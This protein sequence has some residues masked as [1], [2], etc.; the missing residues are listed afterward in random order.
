VWLA[1]ACSLPAPQP[2]P[3]GAPTERGLY[4]VRTERTSPGLVL[5]L[6]DAAGH[7]VDDAALWPV[8][9]GVLVEPGECDSIEEARCFHPGGLYT[10]RLP[11]L[12]EPVLELDIEGDL[13]RDRVVIRSPGP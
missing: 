12:R 4:R 10:L 8:Q 1:A 5:H 11:S 3:P 9:E 2:E 7:P 6:T 13:G